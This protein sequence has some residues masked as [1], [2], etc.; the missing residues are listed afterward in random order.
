MVADR[1]TARRSLLRERDFALIWWAGTVLLTG[2][3][4][5]FIVLPILVYEHTRSPL[6][7]A[8]MVF[9]GALPTALIGQIAGVVTDRVDRRRLLIVT[10]LVVAGLTGGYLLI[11]AQPWWTLVVLAFVI[12]SAGQFLGPAEHALIPEVVPHDRLGE[13]AGLNALN[14]N[15]ARLVGP[16]TGGLLYAG[17]GFSMFVM[18]VVTLNLIAAALLVA[19]SAERPFTPPPAPR[20]SLVRAWRT[21]AAAVWRH[22]RLRLVVGLL[23]VTA[24]GEGFLAA[25]LPPLVG[26]V[27]G[28]GAG[29]LGL[30]MSAQ[31]IGGILGAWWA[32]RITDRHDPLL[33]LGITCV[34]G[35]VLLAAV[36]NYGWIYPQ[37]WPAVVLTAL[38][39]VPFAIFGATQVLVLQRYAAPGMRGRVFALAIGIMAL[40]QLAGILLA[41][42]TGEQWGAAVINVDA[43]AYLVV[44]I[45]ALHITLRSRRD[46][47][48]T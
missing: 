44:G 17:F 29:T 31:A 42:I 47:T 27:I 8:L 21:G 25:L 5:K 41:G 18:A 43:V 1:T 36:F 32:T 14:N 13:G 10:N 15:I 12:S 33:V 6:A 7:T 48:P 46:A 38:I 35:A 37:A 4:A 3:H 22:R 26:N 19:V 24:F 40:T 20:E 16:M 34:V 39:G 11:Q 30:I 2:S 23:A 45:I 9:G 28:G